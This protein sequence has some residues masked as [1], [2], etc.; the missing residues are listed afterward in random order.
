LITKKAVFA[1][2]NLIILM[3]TLHN[4]VSA[5]AINGCWLGVRTAALGFGLDLHYLDS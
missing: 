1:A 5:A 2:I 3:N 4:T